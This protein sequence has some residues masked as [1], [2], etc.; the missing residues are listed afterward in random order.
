[1]NDADHRPPDCFG[2]LDKVFPCRRDGLRETPPGCMACGQKTECLRA[3]VAGADG[4]NVREE[5]V[6]RAYAAG[7]MG[8]LERWARRKTIEKRRRSR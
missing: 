6:D 4:L 5:M 1:M 2:N 3:A 7:A 8:F